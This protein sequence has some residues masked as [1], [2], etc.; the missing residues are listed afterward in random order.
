MY[1]T[2]R[3]EEGQVQNTRSV[4]GQG[5]WRP[6]NEEAKA[7]FKKKVTEKG[8]AEA[9]RSLHDMQKQVGPRGEINKFSPQEH[10]RKHVEGKS[11]EE[12]KR[13]ERAAALS[14]RPTERKDPSETSKTKQGPD[15]RSS[16]D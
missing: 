11:A 15:M 10:M 16:V 7:E 12:V 4:D 9:K 14:L 3:D 2:K 6:L 1:E 8:D 5:R 13:R